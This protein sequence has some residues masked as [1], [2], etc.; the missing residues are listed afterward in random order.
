MSTISERVSVPRSPISGPSNFK[1]FRDAAKT[2]LEDSF[3]QTTERA[4]G[5]YTALQSFAADLKSRGVSDTQ[6]KTELHRVGMSNALGSTP[7]GHL[8][9]AVS[10]WITSVMTKDGF[11]DM[12][13]I[14]AA[15]AKNKTDR[16]SAIAGFQKDLEY[17]QHQPEGKVALEMAT[18]IIEQQ[19]AADTAR[20]AELGARVAAQDKAN[21]EQGLSPEE[22]LVAHVVN[23]FQSAGPADVAYNQAHD[24]RSSAIYQLAKQAKDRLLD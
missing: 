14:L 6:I 20:E 9:P 1:A 23:G 17:A 4:D 10:K 15:R 24:Q 16:D 22:S 5:I 8:F 11:G 3:R 18:P 21:A 7:A 2:D 13:E 19:V 12:M